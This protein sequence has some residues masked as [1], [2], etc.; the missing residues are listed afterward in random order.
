MKNEEP[1]PISL[2]ELLSNT[3]ILYQ[4]CPYIPISGLLNLA[5][6]CK[7]FQHLIYSTPNVFRYLD[8]STS[9]GAST[10]F[11]PIDAG[12]ET[13]RSERIDEAVTEEDFFSGPLRGIFSNLK[14]RRVLQDVQILILDGLSVTAELIRE[15]VCEE[16]FNVRILSIRGVKNL[17]ERKLKQVLKYIVR[18]GRP[19]GTPKLRGLY[20]FTPRPVPEN[21]SKSPP[22]T[23]KVLP[24]GGVT[25]SVGAQL[26][27]HWNQRSQQ[28]LSAAIAPDTDPWYR[29]S[30]ALSFAEHLAD[31]ADVLS[32]CCGLVAFDAV[33]CRGPRH[34]ESRLVAGDG[35]V[36]QS[37][38]VDFLAP[39]SATVALGT[40]GCQVCH[41]SPEGPAIPGKSPSDQL[42]LLDP[43]PRHTSSI[44]VAQKIA[45]SSAQSSSSLPLVVRCKPCLSD[46]WCE[47]CNKFWCETCYQTNETSKFTRLQKVEAVENGSGVGLRMGIKVHLGLCI[48]DCLVGEMYN[49][50]GSGGIVTV[51]NAADCA[52]YATQRPSET[53]SR[54]GEGT[55]LCIMR[56][57]HLRPVTGANPIISS[58]GTSIPYGRRLIAHII[59]KRA[60][61]SPDSVFFSLQRSADPKNGFQDIG[62]GQLASAINQA[63]R[64][65][66][67]TLGKSKNFDTLAYIG[68]SDLR[69]VILTVAT[70]KAG[71]KAFFSSPRN[72]LE[73]HLSLL[74]DTDCKLF[75]M[76]KAAPPIVKEVLSKRTMQVY[77]IP[78]LDEW[79]NAERGPL[80]P[81]EQTFDQARLDPFVVL[82]TSGS[83]GLPKPVVVARGTVSATDAF[84]EMPYI[85]QAPTFMEAWKDSR[86]FLG[87]PPFHA[88]G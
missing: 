76:P 11:T 25:N 46:R 14:R 52:R 60:Q 38:V 22:A 54:V 7:S 77:E 57:L 61:D 70:Q 28:A 17:N 51:L 75:L 37:K 4:T 32:L 15:I 19:S 88:A 2:L 63:A 1:L 83:T 20:F 73:A 44:S 30:G 36:D 21:L 59:D 29:P 12:G 85:G 80:Y 87:M 3:L 68:P 8:L 6:T 78:E 42:P 18:P 81:F 58:T 66:E 5:A 49:G 34:N 47:G 64:W 62:Y 24:W 65:I 43:P 69:Y 23:N 79:L 48:E 82:H 86:V 56:V 33:L 26:G 67:K 41:S 71:Y 55:A 72:S 40:T 10:E 50:A 39:M 84:F 35:M 74:E 16:P 45:S 31:W 13:W 53:A 9:K 27:T